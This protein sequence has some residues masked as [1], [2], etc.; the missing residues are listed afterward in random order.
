MI[1]RDDLHMWLDQYRLKSSDTY[2]VD[3]AA[4][5]L[6][7][8][9]Q[10]AYELVRGGLLKVVGSGV[11]VL[12]GVRITTQAIN[13]FRS[14]YVSLAEIVKLRGAQPRKLLSQLA[15]RPACGPSV[16][17]VRQYFF[18]RDEVVNAIGIPWTAPRSELSSGL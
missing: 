16:D 17:G 4:T 18:R 8:K 15:I 6:N 13:D 3:Q 9:Q 10:V 7:I 2:S 14:A 12:R 5:L 1:Q 11:S